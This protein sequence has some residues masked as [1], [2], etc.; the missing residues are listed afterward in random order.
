M[1]NFRLDVVMTMEKVL[2]GHL[3]VDMIEDKFGF[4]G[5]QVWDSLS[6]YSPQQLHDKYDPLFQQYNSKYQESEEEFEAFKKTTMLRKY[7]GYA[8]GYEK[9]TISF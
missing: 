9:N 7:K 4:V 3:T 5:K 1:E 8:P 2:H 6:T